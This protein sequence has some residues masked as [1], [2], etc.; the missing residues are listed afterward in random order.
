MLAAKSLFQEKVDQFKEQSGFNLDLDLNTDNINFDFSLDVDF[1]GIKDRFEDKI[2]RI[3]DFFDDSSSDESDSDSSSDSEH[4]KFDPNDDALA[5]SPDAL[6]LAH[7]VISRKKTHVAATN[8]PRTK[9][10]YNSTEVTTY[11]IES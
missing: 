2:D 7:G 6:M 1:D 11:G 4:N 10:K 8:Y 5:Y 3:R 9:N